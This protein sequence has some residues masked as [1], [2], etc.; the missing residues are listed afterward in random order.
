MRLFALNRP[1][2]LVE[3]PFLHSEAKLTVELSYR[4]TPSVCLRCCSTMC[5]HDKNKAKQSLTTLNTYT[6]ICKHTLSFPSL[7]YTRARAR[8][9]TPI[10]WKE[11]VSSTEGRL[12]PWKNTKLGHEGKTSVVYYCSTFAP[13]CVYI[14]AVP[15]RNVNTNYS[16]MDVVCIWNIFICFWFEFTALHSESNESK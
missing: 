7:T 5:N 6:C 15:T 12:Q 10:E 16:D 14:H 4:V 3:Y 8:T 2:S 13:V 11:D 9:H 1:E